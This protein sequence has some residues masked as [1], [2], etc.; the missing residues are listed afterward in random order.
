MMIPRIIILL[1]IFFF[2]TK[3]NA[4]YLR[5][6]LIPDV[7][8]RE[9]QISCTPVEGE[10]L[11]GKF[12][13]SLNYPHHFSKISPQDYITDFLVYYSDQTIDTIDI[14]KG[15]V[16]FVKPVSSFTYK[17][18]ENYGYDLFFPTTNYFRN[19]MVLISMPYSLIFQEENSAQE[20]EISVFENDTLNKI[21]GIKSI[22]EWM[23][24]PLALSASHNFL[25][26]DSISLMASVNKLPV[27]R[28]V[29][30]DLLG[31]AVF[32]TQ[33]FQVK[34]NRLPKKLLFI[35][36]T[37]SSKSGAISLDNAA[38]F[39]F[40]ENSINNFQYT[41][42]KTVVHEMLHWYLPAGNSKTEPQNL[43]V[44]E[45]APEYLAIKSL[46][47]AGI[48]SERKFL[49]EMQAK[50]SLSNKYRDLSLENLSINFKSNP[51]YYEAFY[52][53]GVVA[54]WLLDNVVQQNSS[55]S[56]EKLLLGD[57]KFID[58]QSL[59]TLN[60]AM[61]VF[62]KEI[63]HKN[64]DIDYNQYLPYWGL[65]YEKQRPYSYTATQDIE[66]VM[67]QNQIMVV[68][69]ANVKV[70]Q[71]GDVIQSVNGLKKIKEIEELLSNTKISDFEFAILRNGQKLKVNFSSPK[72]SKIVYDAVSVIPNTSKEQKEAWKRYAN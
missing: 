2:N 63:V 26:S 7:E 14:S 23:Q 6:L 9:I 3:I 71:K 66:L 55:F 11:N 31:K 44:S 54:M 4:Q 37:L 16:E 43:W 39:Y 34:D 45:A 60:D 48:I 13:F 58:E 27:H 38:I 18:L 42:L 46:F 67:V 64:P 57:F 22:D 30:F 32:S 10:L 52:S 19:D 47:K 20:I 59:L 17:V 40:N 51:E 56:L 41:I 70:L 65:V 69:Q 68:N 53:K 12:S 49:E 33:Y 24:S 35:F 28:D 50:I 5:L 21:L 72:Q 29:F 25:L 1:F 61:A 36:D 62:E 8:N 15:F